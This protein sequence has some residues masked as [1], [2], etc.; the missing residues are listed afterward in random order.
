MKKIVQAITVLML[1]IYGCIVPF[2]SYASAA[3]KSYYLISN[4]STNGSSITDLRLTL[5]TKKKP[6][7]PILKDPQLLGNRRLMMNRQAVSAVPSLP[8]VDDW[9]AFWVDNLSSSGGSYSQKNFQ[10]L[11]SK[12]SP[13]VWV[14]DSQISKADAAELGE[15]FNRVHALDVST[16]GHESDVDHNGKVNLLCYDIQDGYKYGNDGYVAGYFD[17]IDLMANTHSNRS[18]VLY[19]DTYPAMGTGK[20][21]VVSNV[22]P[23][24]AHELQHMINFNQNVFI[25][26]H[27][28]MDVWMDEG[29][30]MAAEQMYR[31][32]ALD[33]QIEYY[34]ESQTIANGQSLIYWGDHQDLLANYAL[35]YLFMEYLR[36]QSG[37]G[38]SIFKELINDRYSDYQAVQDVIHKYIDPRMTFGEF[39]TDFRTALF[40]NNRTGRFGF[41]D[42][43]GFGA[44]DQRI[45]NGTT[46]NL[47]GGASVIALMSAAS[48]PKTHPATMT[49]TNL[50]ASKFSDFKAP[51][52]PL[53]HSVTDHSSVVTGRAEKNAVIM[54]DKNGVQ[55][56]IG[57]ADVNGIFRV[58]IAK[59]KAG[60]EFKIYAIDASGNKSNA[61]TTKVI[62]V[63]NAL[64]SSQIRI[65]NNKGKSDN[66]I[67]TGLKAGDVLRIYHAHWTTPL[68][69]TSTGS[70][71]SISVKQLGKESG[72]INVTLQQPG[73]AASS[74][75]MFAYKGEKSAVLKRNQINITNKKHRKDSI[76]ITHIKKGDLIRVYNKNKRL[77]VMKKSRDASLVLYVNQLGKKK[78]YVYITIA[79]AYMSESGKKVFYFKKE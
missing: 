56:A 77:I 19:I 38:T 73:Y 61:Q 44:L 16:F 40:L 71:K 27:N 12:G 65:T 5:N 43:S 26:K 60:T 46:L 29:L 33:D 69:V 42:E 18:E 30:A 28:Q 45:A 25:E 7:E 6:N 59:Q 76:K 62:A 2:V 48:I 24:L 74:K 4:E 75:T 63:T 3:S 47:R 22:Y 34:D 70:S 78:G 67:V 8:K 14:A 37:Q 54:V 32:Q 15:A 13:D 50:S 17:P 64:K 51:T 68:T 1:L 11:Y 21:K 66:I 10:L 41:H 39:M 35:S 9:K 52:A 31:G 53:V 72:T 20:T 58:T 36:I 49:Y 55:I 57:D 23:T 79:H